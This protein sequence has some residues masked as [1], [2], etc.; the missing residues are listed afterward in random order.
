VFPNRVNSLARIL[1]RYFNDFLLPGRRQHVFRRSARSTPNI[2]RSVIG[3]RPSS[4][5]EQRNRAEGCGA[6]TER[7]ERTIREII[8]E[9]G[10]TLSPSSGSPQRIRPQPVHSETKRAPSEAGPASRRREGRPPPLSPTSGD[11]KKTNAGVCAVGHE[12]GSD[13][14]FRFQVQDDTDVHQWGEPGRVCCK[15]LGHHQAG[16][17]PT[18][19]GCFGLIAVATLA[20][21]RS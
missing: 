12:G 10:W 3:H 20:T 9:L 19:S 11:I 4:K 14:H 2:R 8:G 17:R 15:D 18:K 21:A 5:N 7:R 16:G 13:A 6:L 1:S